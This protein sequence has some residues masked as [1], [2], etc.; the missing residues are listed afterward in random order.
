MER[1]HVGRSR[2]EIPADRIGPVNAYYGKRW[3]VLRAEGVACT[4]PL[5]DFEVSHARD[6]AEPTNPFDPVVGRPRTRHL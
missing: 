3:S 1:A 4:P 5:Y 6:E 2:E